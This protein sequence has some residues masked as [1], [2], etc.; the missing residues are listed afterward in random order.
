[1][2]INPDGEIKFDYGIYKKDKILYRRNYNID[3]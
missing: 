1:M 3:F 2:E